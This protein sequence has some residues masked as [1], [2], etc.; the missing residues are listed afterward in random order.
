MNY[1]ILMPPVA[2][3]VVL[4]FTAIFS[5]LCS[6]LSFKGKPSSG[7]PY[8]CGEEEFDEYAQPDYSQFFPFAFFFTIA[9][10]ATLMLAT[11][12][13]MSLRVFVTA[14]V[15]IV[16]VFIGLFILLWG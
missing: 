11:V 12:P 6:L 7:E 10:V 1:W 8:A 4:A 3:V 16:A 9:H 5:Y 2:F 13:E 14:A 15:Y